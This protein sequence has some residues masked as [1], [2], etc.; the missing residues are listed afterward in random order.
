M[1]TGGTL[2]KEC[3]ATAASL[4]G[5]LLRTCNAIDRPNTAAEEVATDLPCSHPSGDLGRL[6]I[7]GLLQQCHIQGDSDFGSVLRRWIGGCNA[8]FFRLQKMVT[9]NRGM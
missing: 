9:Q 5:R 2:G 8:T 1:S 4:L 3:R 7:R 6:I